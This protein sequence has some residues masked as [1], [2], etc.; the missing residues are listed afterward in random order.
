MPVE[1]G[2]GPSGVVRAETV[3]VS[4]S[5]ASIRVQEGMSGQI[6]DE[7]VLVISPGDRIIPAKGRVVRRTNAEDLVGIEFLRV[8][9]GPRRTL[10]AWLGDPRTVRRATS[11]G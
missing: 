9:P 4:L 6:A 5:G 3:D 10:R 7:V 1:I 11:P 8:S 2:V